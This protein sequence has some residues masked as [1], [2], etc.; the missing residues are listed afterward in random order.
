MSETSQCLSE[1]KALFWSKCFHGGGVEEEEE[2]G[3]GG[4]IKLI[5]SPYWLFFFL[6]LLFYARLFLPHGSDRLFEL[7]GKAIRS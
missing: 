2:E 5:F 7:K 4:G 1:V 3:R 6:L